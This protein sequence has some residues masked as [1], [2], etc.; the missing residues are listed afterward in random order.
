METIPGHHLNELLQAVGDPFHFPPDSPQDQD[1]VSASTANYEPMEAVVVLIEFASSELWQSHLHRLNFASYEDIVSTKEGRDSALREMFSTA[2]EELRG[3][4]CTPTKIVTAIR[5]LEELGC[6]NTVQVVIAWAWVTGM[7]D[8]MDRDGWKL[9]EGETLRFYQA[10]GIQ[11]LAA[12]KQH[13]IQN[14]DGRL[15][16]DEIHLFLARYKGPPFRVGCSR[17][18]SL[19]SSWNVQG[20]QFEWGVDFVISQAC[21]LRRLRQLFWYHATT[22]EVVEVGEV[23]GKR[24]VLLGHSV[25]PVPFVDWECDYP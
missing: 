25:T 19:L 18:P 12:L 11:Y 1:R 2:S 5:R 22:W 21:Q 20:R 3:F 17:R 14:T 4:L 24:G 7:A 16:R 15:K 9:V 13:I 23:R 6:L 10:H 8:A